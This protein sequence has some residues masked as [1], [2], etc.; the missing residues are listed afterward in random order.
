M[1]TGEINHAYEDS[2]KLPEAGVQR[3]SWLVL[4]GGGWVPGENVEALLPFPTPCLCASAIW[5]SLNYIL[6]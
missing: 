3:A 5:L 2:L 4:G 1:T 6:S